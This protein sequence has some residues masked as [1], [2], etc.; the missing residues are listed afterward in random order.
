MEKILLT[1]SKH[2]IAESKSLA[3]QTPCTILN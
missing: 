3:H 1:E 2:K